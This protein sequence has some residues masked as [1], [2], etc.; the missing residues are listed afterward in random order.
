MQ[1]R[2]GPGSHGP[3]LGAR[4]LQRPAAPAPCT[5]AGAGPALGAGL[6]L[7]SASFASS[8]AGRNIT[9]VTN[10]KGPTAGWC[11]ATLVAKVRLALNQA[12]SHGWQ[13]CPY[14]AA[15]PR[16]SDPEPGIAPPDC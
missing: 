3:C 10:S 4:A 7:T 1:G 16:R 15:R 9:P 6:A 5:G 14:R 11:S 8:N 2:T 13:D 12:P